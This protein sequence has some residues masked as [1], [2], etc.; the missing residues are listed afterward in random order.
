MLM[1]AINAQKTAITPAYLRAIR[2]VGLMPIS[3]SEDPNKVN[4][5]PALRATSILKTSRPK[6]LRW[7][8]DHEE[9]TPTP[10]AVVIVPQAMAIQSGKVFDLAATAII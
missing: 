6:R 3:S 1:V 8:R 2:L 5:K 4:N 10:T 7:A 9:R